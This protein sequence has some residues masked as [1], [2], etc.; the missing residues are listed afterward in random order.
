MSHAATVEAVGEP[1]RV[2]NFGSRCSA[3]LIFQT[4]KWGA[5]AA[6]AVAALGN[7]QVHFDL[8]PYGLIKIEWV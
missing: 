3:P 8:N 4:S 1:D 2:W 5:G 6:G 7:R